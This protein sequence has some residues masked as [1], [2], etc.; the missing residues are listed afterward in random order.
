M[1]G[2]LS[3]ALL[4]VASPAV[5]QDS[6]PADSRRCRRSRRAAPVAYKTKK[7]CRVDRGGRLEHSAHRLHAPSGFRS[8][9]SRKKRE[10]DSEQVKHAEAP[11]GE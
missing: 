3:V 2:K 5:A 11:K 4:I 9:R 7:V 8:S 1:L 10:A 6:A